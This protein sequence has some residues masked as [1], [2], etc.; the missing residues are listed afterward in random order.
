MSAYDSDVLVNQGRPLVA[1]YE[2]VAAAAG[3]GKLASNWLQQDVLRTLKEQNRSIEQYPVP[4]AALGELL[5]IVR[6]GDLDTARAREVLTEMAAGGQSAAAVIA[7]KGYQKVDDSALDG[8]CRQII[9]ANPKIIAEIKAGKQQAIGS[10]I[11]QAKKHNA[12][13]N[14][15]QFKELLLRLLSEEA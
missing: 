10:L 11:G 1:Y 14:P 2:Q 4:A 5:T 6:R 15:G 12:N 13:I 3:D 8:L 9:A 7:A